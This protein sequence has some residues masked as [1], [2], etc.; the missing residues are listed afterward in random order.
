MV[1][2]SWYGVNG[3]PNKK[4]RNSSTRSL[5]SRAYCAWLWVYVV[6]AKNY[7]IF[8]M[9]SAFALTA[10]VRTQASFSFRPNFVI[11][12]AESQ[13]LEL[14]GFRFSKNPIPVLMVW[15]QLNN[16]LVGISISSAFIFKCNPEYSRHNWNTH[17][18]RKFV[19]IIKSFQL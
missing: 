8:T 9:F 3:G 11:F 18:R 5:N 13:L 17:G 1:K 2:N 16:V 7:R 12:N 6:H 15:C 10:S 19:P 14:P 4:K